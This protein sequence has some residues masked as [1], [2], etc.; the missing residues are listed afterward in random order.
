MRYD[1]SAYQQYAIDYIIKHP[2]CAVFL[3]CGL[4]K[5]AITLT[6]IHQMMFDSF[7]VHKVL[8]VAPLHVAEDTWPREIA[9][10][11][12]VRDFRYSVVMGTEKQRLA[13]LEKDADIYIVNRENLKWLVEDSC[14]PFDFDMVVLDE[15][16]SFKNHQSKRF[17]SFLMVRP[18]VKRVVGL[19][20]TPA[21]NGLMDLWAEFKVI[22][23]GQRLGRFIGKYRLNYFEPDKQDYRRGI[24]YSYKPRMGAEEQIYDAISDITVSMKAKDNIKMP[25]LVSS[26][27]K[28]YMDGKLAS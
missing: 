19:T 15:L 25:E 22:D 12:H 20:G 14:I 24:V 9:K 23:L 11:D 10:W 27:Y 28:V 13:A 1:P 17:K 6:A 26:E 18:K 5:T 7:E 16:S 2:Y 21:P 8:V 4:G 3:D